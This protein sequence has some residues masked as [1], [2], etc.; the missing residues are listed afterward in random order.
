M[1]GVILEPLAGCIKWLP[2]KLDLVPTDSA[3]DEGC[4]QHPVVI[5][6]TKP[7]NGRVEFLII[8]SF[9][10]LDLESK[11][12]NQLLARLDHLPIAPSKAHPDNGIL[13]LLKDSSPELRKKSYVKTR[14]KH[15][16]LLASLQPYNRQGPDIFLSKRSYK[17]LVKHSKFTESPHAPLFYALA[18]GHTPSRTSREHDLERSVGIEQRRTVE[19]FAVLFN[20]LRR[21]TNDNPTNRLHSGFEPPRSHYIS[22]TPNITASRAERQPL[23][24][25]RQEY[26]PRYY[27]S[28]TI[29]PTTYPIQS[30]NRGGSSKP[31]D[32]QKVRKC[33]KIVTYICLALLAS[34]GVYRGGYWIVIACGRALDWIKEAFHS[35]AGKT[36]SLWSSSLQTLRL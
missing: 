29:L 31:F 17:T 35:V 25:A 34:Y 18:D 26:L 3:I 30:E 13:L 28:H 12:P 8:T 6:S 7:H 9:G 24:P 10:G 2:R 19:D 15:S 16:I 22:H 14:D 32:W 36:K 20:S 33:V 23:F 11:F 27:G 1:P 4:C 5:L 21:T